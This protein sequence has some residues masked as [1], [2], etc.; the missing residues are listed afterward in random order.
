VRH[1]I[2]EMADENNND[3]V[4]GRPPL[5][6]GAVAENVAE[7][8]VVTPPIDPERHRQIVTL[9]LLGLLALVIV[10]HYATLVLLEWNGKKAETLSNAFNATLPVISGLTGSSV[11][12]YF[13]RLGGAK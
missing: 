11:T 8:I 5:D 9:C 3:V 1:G 4:E 7:P 13:T 2:R 10:G 6:G 12:Y